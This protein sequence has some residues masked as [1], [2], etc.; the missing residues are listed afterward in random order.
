[1]IE[2]EEAMDSRSEI[3]HEP[4]AEGRNYGVKPGGDEILETWRVG[5][6]ACL[7]AWRNFRFA[8]ASFLPD[9]EGRTAWE[10]LDFTEWSGVGLKIVTEG[11]GMMVEK[12]R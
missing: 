4:L 6:K 8:K 11:L 9:P 3:L 1:M 7:V 2:Q 10:D 5:G 12:K